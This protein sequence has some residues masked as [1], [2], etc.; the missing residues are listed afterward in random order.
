M[1]KIILLLLFT[2][3]F[4]GCK[5]EAQSFPEIDILKE[6]STTVPFPIAISTPVAASPFVVV[7]PATSVEEE[8]AQAM[9]RTSGYKTDV[10][11]VRLFN[12]NPFGL[13]LKPDSGYPTIV[14]IIRILSIE[15][16]MTPLE[17][18]DTWEAAKAGILRLAGS[19]RITGFHYFFT[20]NGILQSGIWCPIEML[21]ITNL[22]DG[23][24]EPWPGV[25]PLPPEMAR[26]AGF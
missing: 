12:D 6:I 4:G 3:I 25:A 21:E 2:L 8:I 11:D 26:F 5:K 14:F 20:E 7:S 16:E 18:K 24:C 9:E 10:Y 17:Q 22:N 13:P 19:T 15:D 23:R 1:K